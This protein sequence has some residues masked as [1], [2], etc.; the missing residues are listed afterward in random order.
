ML[1]ADIGG[2]SLELV[3]AASGAIT[4]LKSLPLGAV[5][6][7]E[8]QLPDEELHT[9]IGALL[10]AGLAGTES[11]G[12]RIVGSGGTFAT[13][14]SMVLAA[15]GKASLSVHG[16]TVSAEEVGR[17]KQALTLIPL[18]QRR[19][20]PGLRPERADIIVAGVAVVA[21][22]LKAVASGVTVSG[23]GLRDGLLLEMTGLS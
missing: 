10:R 18:E 4:F 19:R 7:T 2:G 9:H 6:L 11:K 21:E 16:T 3:G 1:V 15:R 13:L 5:R 17:I 12:S 23:Y 8:M 14:A 20:I 22:L